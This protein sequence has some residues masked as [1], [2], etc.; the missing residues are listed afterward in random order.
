MA[1]MTLTFLRPTCERNPM[2]DTNGPNAQDLQYNMV[3]ARLQTVEAALRLI[4]YRAEIL[5][6]G[7]WQFNDKVDM[8]LRELLLIDDTPK[9]SSAQKIRDWLA[10]R[11]GPEASP[12]QET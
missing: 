5:M 9:G 6:K 3:A 4:D 8:V 11:P 10:S 7:F 12:S 1:P 2:P